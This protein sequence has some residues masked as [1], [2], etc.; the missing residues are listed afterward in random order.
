ML[1]GHYARDRALSTLTAAFLNVHRRKGSSPLS[2]S[3]FSAFADAG[4]GRRAQSPTE[5]RGALM[6][7][8]LAM[9]GSVSHDG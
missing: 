8:T 5:Q 4:L 2:P 6:A 1:E 9:G 7:L 3:L